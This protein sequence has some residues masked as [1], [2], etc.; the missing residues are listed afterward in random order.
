MYN[1]FSQPQ[2]HFQTLTKKLFAD[3]KFSFLS[4]LLT[5]VFFL[6]IYNNQ[7]RDVSRSK[8]YQNVEEIPRFQTIY[9]T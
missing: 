2:L 1:T 9:N 8:I 6:T 4:F 7:K 3:Q 5:K